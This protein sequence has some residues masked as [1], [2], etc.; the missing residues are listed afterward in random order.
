MVLTI[1]STASG[2]R[3]AMPGVITAAPPAK[4]W[5]SW[6]L[7]S[8]ILSVL[9]SMMESSLV[10]RQMDGRNSPTPAHTAGAGGFRELRWWVRGPRPSGRQGV[11]L[12]WS[13]D[14]A[15]AHSNLITSG[16]T[17]GCSRCLAGR[18]H[19][20]DGAAVPKELGQLRVIAEPQ[21]EHVVFA[22]EHDGLPPAIIERLLSNHE[23]ARRNLVPGPRQAAG[24]GQ[25]VLVVFQ[26]QRRRGFE[27]QRG[28]DLAVE[29]LS[30]IRHEPPAVGIKP[31][32]GQFFGNGGHVLGGRLIDLEVHEVCGL[33][34]EVRLVVVK[35]G[36][37][38]LLLVVVAKDDQGS[39]A[40]VGGSG[41]PLGNSG[42]C[43]SRFGAVRSGRFGFLLRHDRSPE[44]PKGPGEGPAGR[45]DG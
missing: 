20:R 1:R 13:S 31:A 28:K 14:A 2:P 8:R 44:K 38:R 9:A 35:P 23:M 37:P 36:I 27:R 45:V 19:Q 41:G 42:L 39:S 11:R 25:A 3:A 12:A 17:V 29:V 24:G 18:I 16:R 30:Y 34:H 33:G 26:A 4:F 6:S 40:V 21:R 32:Y 43:A 22:L 15:Y 10:D 7:S 5:R